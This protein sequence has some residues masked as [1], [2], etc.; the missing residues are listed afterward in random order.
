MEGTSVTYYLKRKPSSYPDAKVNP[1]SDGKTKVH[2][3]L[4]HQYN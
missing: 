3:V 4:A 2:I 1:H